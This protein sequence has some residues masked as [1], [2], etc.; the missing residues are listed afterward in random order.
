MKRI[1]ILWL[2]V[3][4]SG[5]VN[6]SGDEADGG[7]GGDGAGADAGGGGGEGGSG[8]L[9]I[10][11]PAPGKE[12]KRNDVG[13]LGYL[14]AAV[15]FELEVP[16]GTHKVAYHINGGQERD[17][18]G[19]PD[20]PLTVEIR[21]SGTANVKVIAYDKDGAELDHASVE[22]EARDPTPNGC[23]GWL[24][25]YQLE[26][27]IGP[28]Q[29]GVEDPV[30]VK[31]PI[32]GV[33]YRYVTL[34][35]PRTSWFMDCEMAKTLARNAP[36][37]REREV[38]EVADI[39]LYNYRCI[40][41]EG[42]PP[43]C[44]IGMSE[45]SWGTA[46]DRAGFKTRDGTYYSVLNHWVIDPDGVATC[47]ARTE[48]PKDTFLHELICAEWHANLWNIALTPNYNSIHRNHFHTDLTPGGDTINLIPLDS[49][50]VDLTPG[51]WVGDE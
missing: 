4:C 16:E 21:A 33:R 48:N 14:V 12:F 19:G 18:V 43:N 47:A 51:G 3:G 34:S 6:M 31:M 10:L 1:A 26:Y 36:I 20:F 11:S 17:R 8:K 37:L 46:I 28:N 25:L 24:D 39:G 13:Q 38:V 15:P 50:D 32:N 27:T 5:T 40:N 45:H 29:P 2:L 30:T 44:T 22:L 7:G 42:T 49:S 35:S 23:H 9:R 41:H